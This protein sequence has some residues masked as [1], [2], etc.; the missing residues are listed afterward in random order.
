VNWAIVIGINQ[1]DLAKANLKGAV[2][3]ALRMREWLKTGGQVPEENIYLLLSAA[4]GDPDVPEGLQSEPATKNKIVEVCDNLVTHSQGQGERFYFY[5]SGHGL[6]DRVNFSYENALVASDFTKL[7]TDNSLSLRSIM[8]YFQG[9]QFRDQFF[10]IDAC[11]NI[12]WDTTQKGEFRIGAMPRPKRI[13]FSLQAIQQFVCY[14]TSPGVK[15]V[16]IGESNNERGAFTEVLLDALVRGRGKAKAWDMET[17]SYLVRWER[18]FESYLVEEIRKKRLRVTTDANRP[19]FQI[20]RQTGERGAEWGSNP[21][22][23][24]FKRDEVP[25]APLEIQIAPFSVES[26]IEVEVQREDVTIRKQEQ[27]SSIPVNFMLPQKEYTVRAKAIDHDP[28]MPEGWYVEVY[29]ETQLTVNLRPKRGAPPLTSSIPP[30]GGGG[31][32]AIDPVMTFDGTQ[33]LTPGRGTAVLIRDTESVEPV[34]SKYLASRIV[35]N[36]VPKTSRGISCSLREAG[37]VNERQRIKFKEKVQKT[38]LD[39]GCR[40]RKN[41]IPNQPDRTLREVVDSLRIRAMLSAQ[42]TRSDR[43][44]RKGARSSLVVGAHERTVSRRARSRRMARLVV[45]SRDPLAALE[46]TDNTG[47]VLKTGQ[48][49]L[50]A[51]D[52]KPGYYRARLLTPEGGAVEQLIELT[53]GS[54]MTAHLIAPHMTDVNLLQR[55]I[56]EANFT[57][58]PDNVLQVTEIEDPR[59][60]LLVSPQISTILTLA[61]SVDNFN[62]SR[63]GASRLRALGLQT[64]GKALPLGA[65]SGLHVLFGVEGSTSKEASKYLNEVKLRSWSMSE[66]I[67]KTPNKAVKFSKTQGLA[68]FAS[69]TQPG[70]Y[71]FSIEM[72]N[73]PCV[74]FALAMLPDRVTM[75]VVHRLADR[76]IRIFQYLPGLKPKPFEEHT[77]KHLRQLELVERFYLSGRLDHA[78]QNAIELLRTKW[79]EPIAGCLGGYLMLKLGK[80]KELSVASHNLTHYFD[81]LSDSHVLA[82][83][84]LVSLKKTEDAIV[85]YHRA[86]DR[87]LPILADGLSRLYD[88]V[89]LYDIQHPGVTLLKEVFNRRVGNLLWTAWTP[90][91]LS[92]GQFLTGDRSGALLK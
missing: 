60:G 62:P 16:E 58:H 68:E 40:I 29:D 54:R 22:M 79:I 32:S 43:G 39:Y 51:A 31:N 5:Y 17:K 69:A 76:Q 65:Q 87:G 47:R 77:P 18:L 25:D 49:R 11:R 45:D 21:I 2:R 64:F 71:W 27:V 13:D 14:A 74:V 82:A 33:T 9:V 4:P 91:Q 7:F 23:A 67:P 85:A 15:A 63:F 78:Y 86:L 81:E 36:A 80:A 90:E 75:L 35:R 8:E 55:V 19:L 3:D 66:H 56:Q 46:I 53:Y 42:G 44:T 70:P 50:E 61:G 1:Y 73:R 59:I 30:G 89:R 72:P 52:L 92:P 34:L 84:Y 20:P 41:Q 83:E 48:G 26:R 57:V 37:V 38:L 6:T 28:E 88:A 12:P 24:Q 10:L